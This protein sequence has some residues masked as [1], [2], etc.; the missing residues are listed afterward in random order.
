MPGPLIGI[1]VL[2][3]T[4]LLPGPFA[5][6]YLADLGANVLKISTDSRPD[7]V[8]HMEPFI[9]TSHK[10]S[11]VAAYLDRGKRSIQLNLKNPLAM[12]IIR[13]LIAEYDV[14]VEQ[15]RPGV[16]SRLGLDYENLKK[17]NPSLIYCS[18]TGYGQTGPLKNR[19]GHDINYLARSG[20]M[21]YSGRT[22][23]GPTLMAM[24][25]A[26]MAAGSFNALIGI[27]AAIINRKETG[28][29]QHIDIS[30]TDGAVSF[31]AVYGSC[32][33]ITGKE[34]EPEG[35]PLNGGSL[36][37]FYKT[38]DGRYLSFGGLEPKFF[39]AFCEAIGR[40]DL[41][42]GG[43][44]TED[45]QS[46]KSQINKIFKSKTR[47]EWVKIFERVDACVEP[48]LTLSEAL[49]NK[50]TEERE[51]VIEIDLPEKGRVRQIANPIKFSQSRQEYKHSGFPSGTHTK[52]VLF[53][54]GYTEAEIDLL[55][56]R[57]VF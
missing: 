10:L 17:I 52:D 40:Q 34:P 48:V 41:I 37:D 4:T 25:I 15:F 11:A 28:E 44:L 20:L 31:N 23:T 35:L 43:I 29:G 38:K 7:P 27:L 19:A 9:P 46:V 16:M 53:E 47:D 42:R 30:M 1:N 21:G 54:L 55:R 18:I 2:D 3:F 51:M 24:Q 49:N 13:Q 39:S 26:D 33:L 56:E 50:H 36:Y 6:L 32:F 12:G 8:H 22:E 57:G 14:V 45:L 5:T